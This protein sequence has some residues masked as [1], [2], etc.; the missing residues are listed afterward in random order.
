MLKESE[1]TS[2]KAR[3]ILLTLAAA[4]CL[5]LVLALGLLAY[6]LVN[7]P[8]H[9]ALLLTL[10]TVVCPV[11]LATLLHT[12]GLRGLLH[13]DSHVDPGSAKA[14][15]RS[16]PAL[17]ITVPVMTLAVLWGIL[18]VAIAVKKDGDP[19]AWARGHAVVT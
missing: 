19:K 4:V 6:G 15:L 5:L 17:L 9:L 1:M 12:T 18:L 10:S 11:V 14:V 7:P 2:G 3:R 13:S 16:H 8:R